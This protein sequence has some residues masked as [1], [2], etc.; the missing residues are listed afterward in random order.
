GDLPRDVAASDPGFRTLRAGH[1]ADRAMVARARSRQL[2]HPDR[3]G[4]SPDGG[5]G[6]VR[7]AGRGRPPNA[8][9]RRVAAH[10]LGRAAGGRKAM[11]YRRT[12]STGSYVL[13][14]PWAP[15]HQGGVTAVVS[16]LE[17]NIAEQGWLA[18]VVVVDAWEA[19][20]PRRSGQLWS[21]RLT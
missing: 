11:S 13:V 7:G 5:G 3:I 1:L 12:E 9:A 18:P 2:L 19:R 14:L 20:V 4:P 21:L 17:R 10:A 15:S 6:M 16:Q 8:P